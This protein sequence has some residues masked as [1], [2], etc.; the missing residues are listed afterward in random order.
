MQ[1]ET[2]VQLA[3]NRYLLDLGSKIF[4]SFCLQIWKTFSSWGP[5]K[6]TILTYA[7]RRLEFS[8][9]LPIGGC[10]ISLGLGVH[11]LVI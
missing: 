9:Q 6:L 10:F 1:T 4:I 11:V 2:L 8:T 5:D 3:V 7:L